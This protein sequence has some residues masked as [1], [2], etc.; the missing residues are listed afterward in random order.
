MIIF[1]LSIGCILLLFLIPKYSTGRILYTESFV[2]ELQVYRKIIQRDLSNISVKIEI[3]HRKLYRIKVL[4]FLKLIF[5]L[6]PLSYSV[7]PNSDG[8]FTFWAYPFDIV[9]V[10]VGEDK[11]RATYTLRHRVKNYWPTYRTLFYSLI[12]MVFPKLLH[13]ECIEIPTTL[14]KTCGYADKLSLL[15]GE[16]LD[17][18]ASTVSKTFSA[19]LVRVGEKLQKIDEVNNIPG[20]FQSIDTK[21]PSALGCGW[22]PTFKYKVPDDVSSGCYILRLIGNSKDDTSFI[23]IIVRPKELKNNIAVIASTN[24][25]H[26]YNSWGGQNYYIN[27]TSFPSK[28]I[29]STHRPFDLYVRN[30]VE[31]TCQVSRDHLLVGERF[32]WAWLEREGIGYDLYSDIDL[33]SEEIYNSM[34]KKYK[35]ILIST[36]NEYW[37][38]EMIEH[39]KDFMKSGGNVISLSGNTV[40][41]EVRFYNPNLIVLDGAYFR[42]QGFNEETVLGIAHDIRGFK[43]GAPYKVLKSDHW[44]FNSTNLKNGDIIG[45]K[46]LNISPDGNAGASGW[47]T[48]K[49]Y[50]YSPED[51][52]LLA[53]GINSENGGA[54]IALFQDP[55]GGSVF[56]VGS[57]TFGGSLLVDDNISRI[58]KNV[59]EKFIS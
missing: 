8:V 1:I 36:H 29:I 37:S 20:T 18:M 2:P 4:S 21:F 3:V 22:E 39:L 11:F 34:L 14:G 48:D 56:S 6:L 9:H 50:P 19:E 24:T 53:K 55:G 57:I 54:D 5:E 33:H 15:P 27:Y 49:I 31:E 28:Y 43:T 32:I 17:L 45:E 59:I 41:K 12:M 44:V 7:K 25:W 16:K 47:E 13:D 52:T 30:P 38:Y 51:I 58:T 23:P 42:H 40:Y 26:A 35:I 46:G 10:T